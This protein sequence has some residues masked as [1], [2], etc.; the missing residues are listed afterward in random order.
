MF[1][2][3]PSFSNILYL[4]YADLFPF[5]PFVK[6]LIQQYTAGLFIPAVPLSY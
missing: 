5:N 4:C 2:F 3:S 6:L 1:M